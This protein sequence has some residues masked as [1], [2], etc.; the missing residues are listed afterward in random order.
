MVYEEES[1]AGVGCELP[2]G[3]GS[4]ACCSSSSPVKKEKM[5][6]K[7]KEEREPKRQKIAQRNEAERQM[8]NDPLS[9]AINNISS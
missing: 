6:I 4:P 3:G 1:E 2:H 7:E 8:Q 5:A 9:A